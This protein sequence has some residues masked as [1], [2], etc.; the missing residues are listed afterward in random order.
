M[1]RDAKEEE[2]KDTGGEGEEKG[3]R[4]KG[5][6]RKREEISNLFKAFSNGF[7]KYIIGVTVNTSREK[8]EAETY[9]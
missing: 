9:I 8:E 2:G 4:R 1:A 3:G 5:R 6:R 7:S